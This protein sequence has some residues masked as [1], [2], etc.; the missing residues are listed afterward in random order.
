MK[1]LHLTTHINPGGITTY[2]L[3]LAQPLRKQGVEMLVASSG[4]D[5]K[6][7]FLKESVPHYEIPIRTKNEVSLKVFFCIPKILKIIRDEKIDLIHAHT[8]VTQAL[9][10]WVSLISRI[11]IITTCHG[12]YKKRLGRVLMPAWGEKVIAIS[13]PVADHLKT[14]FGVPE[15]K[16]QT[17][18]NAI[19]LEKMD[20]AFSKHHPEEIRKRFNISPEAIVIGIIARIV[21]DKGHAYLYEAFKSVKKKLPNSHLM[22]VGDG[23]FRPQIDDWIRRDHLEDCVTMTGFLKDISEPLSIIDIF[24]LPATWREGFGLSIIEAMACRKPAIVTNIW[25]LNSLVQHNKTGILVAPKNAELLASEILR[26]A[27][28]KELRESL[29]TNGREMVEKLFTIGPMSEALVKAYQS[30][31]L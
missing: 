17:I 3:S 22:I 18:Y 25:A 29:G 27:R 8:R 9:A 6:K 4:G 21:E 16:I 30:C 28:D 2:I 20:E 13:E 12:F 31:I 19:N 1:V 15:A 14:D 10:F 11:P 26:L 24:S 23:N 7:D 5:R